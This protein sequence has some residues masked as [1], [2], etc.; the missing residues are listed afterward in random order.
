MRNRIVVALFICITQ[1]VVAQTP[2]IAI[3]DTSTNT[4]IRGLSV[5]NDTVFWVS[6]NNGRVGKCL[7][8]KDVEWNTIVGYEKRDFRDIEA[9]SSQHALIMAI[10]EPAII[11][12][13][14]NGGITWQKVFEDTTTGM[15]L[16]AIYF[17]NKGNGVVVGDPINNQL[18]VATTK[19]CGQTWQ[20][21]T[22]HKGELLANNGEAF[23]ASSGSN[24]S[25]I[26][27]NKK[28]CQPQPLFIVE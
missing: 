6:G 2:T 20:P 22:K 7:N 19:N 13:T 27:I 3:I 15:F 21:F 26:T 28:Q 14:K 5:V 11:L 10:A 16:D 18:Y 12:E 23:F 9:F 25:F 17:D 24:V 8:G 1:N 4:S